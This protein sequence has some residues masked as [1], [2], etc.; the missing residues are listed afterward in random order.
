MR[1]PLLLAGL[2]ALAVG[3]PVAADCPQPA[4]PLCSSPVTAQALRGDTLL[5]D[6]SSS[7]GAP[8]TV[9]WYVTDPGDAVPVDPVAATATLDVTL[10]RSGMWSIGLVARYPHEDPE[11]PGC[12]YF[13]VDCVAV[14]VRSV[15][16]ELADPGPEADLGDDLV[17]D[18]TSSRWGAA[19]APQMTW[20]IDGVA[21][22]ACEGTPTQPSQVTCTIAAA[23][24]GLGSHTVELELRDPSNN[25]V[26]TDSVTVE[27]I[28][29]P[30]Q[31]ADFTWSP[32][33][34]GT[35]TIVQFNVLTDPP[36][37]ATE[38]VSVSWSWG[39]GTSETWTCPGV[40]VACTITS[41]TYYAERRFPVVMT[42]ETLAGETLVI[43]HGVEVGNGEIFSDGF[44]GGLSGGWFPG[45]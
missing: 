11:V 45:P 26:D 36:L 24:L 16:A 33:H 39:D 5:F 44:E 40:W 18:G 20:R 1:N 28:D 29:P 31:T 22:S 23:D 42:L 2:A 37:L 12:L 10:D 15:D 43:L 25:D 13:D 38:M 35:S 17:L 30:P 4:V 41:H 7:Q 34:P 32:F 19:V 6:S 21:W 8:A 3:R 14:E 27:V 9:A